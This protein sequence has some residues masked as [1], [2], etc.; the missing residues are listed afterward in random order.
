MSALKRVLVS[1]LI[2]LLVSGGVDCQT[3]YEKVIEETESKY[4]S[5]YN[6]PFDPRVDFYVNPTGEWTFQG[7]EAYEVYIDAMAQ[8]LEDL[9]S[10]YGDIPFWKS[11]EFGFVIG[12][13]MTTALFLLI[14]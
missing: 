1:L 9:P 11:R 10:N 7:N 5:V 12:V 6:K 8:S 14:P 4:E 3:L 13:T 2:V